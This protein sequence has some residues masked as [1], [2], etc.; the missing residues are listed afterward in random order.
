MDAKLWKC[1]K[2]H[3]LACH[4]SQLRARVRDRRIELNDHPMKVQYV[5]RTQAQI[6]AQSDVVSLQLLFP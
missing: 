4:G 6:T 2:W 3:Q 1:P 5:W